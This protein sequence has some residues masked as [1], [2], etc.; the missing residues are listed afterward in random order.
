[1]SAREPGDK[2]QRSALSSCPR[3]V[4][5]ASRAPCR[6]VYKHRLV[7]L[8]PNREVGRSGGRY[9]D[10]PHSLRT[11]SLHHE[12]ASPGPAVPQHQG[13]ACVSPNPRKSRLQPSR[14]TP[15]VFPPTTQ[16][17]PLLWVV[18]GFS[19]P[20]FP[21]LR[22]CGGGLDGALSPFRLWQRLFVFW[23]YFFFFGL[24]S[25][26]ILNSRDNFI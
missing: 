17:L 8:Y 13:D 9:R 15:K 7:S 18:T 10:C 14:P 11:P 3:S 5:Q 12:A 1:M 4:L 23:V 25:V 26:F 16:A 19:V 21:H 20:Q 6:V 22:N 24:S 2:T